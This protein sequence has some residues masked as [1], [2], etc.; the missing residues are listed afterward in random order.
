VTAPR[1]TLFRALDLWRR[2]VQSG[3]DGQR[4]DSP[5]SWKY[6]ALWVAACWE[7]AAQVAVGHGD[8]DL[9]RSCLLRARAAL[10]PAR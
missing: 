9:A 2:R 3:Q 4:A 5:A 10:V 8:K 1:P 7:Q 6:D